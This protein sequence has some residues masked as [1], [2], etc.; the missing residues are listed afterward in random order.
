MG[1]RICVTNSGGSEENPDS[2]HLLSLLALIIVHLSPSLLT[3]LRYKRKFFLA[4]IPLAWLP[5]E[6]LENTC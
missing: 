6:R 1:D 5:L 3:L 2:P 4:G